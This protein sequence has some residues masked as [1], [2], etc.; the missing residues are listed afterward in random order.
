MAWAV[1]EKRDGDRLTE[2][3][4]HE[5][6]K[7]ASGRGPRIARG[8]RAVRHPDG[9]VVTLLGPRGGPV[10]DAFFTPPALRAFFKRIA[11]EP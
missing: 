5:H 11:D 4:V 7:G 2:I 10:D 9:W 3:T 8:I 1:E 6:F